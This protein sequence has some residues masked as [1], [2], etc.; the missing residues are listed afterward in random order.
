MQSARILQTL[1]FHVAVH[2]PTLLYLECHVVQIAISS[3]EWFSFPSYHK[4]PLLPNNP[5]KVCEYEIIIVFAFQHIT[6]YHLPRANRN[7]VA[8]HRLLL[9]I[10]LIGIACS[11]L[12]NIRFNA[13]RYIDIVLGTTDTIWDTNMRVMHSLYDTVRDES[14]YDN[15]LSLVD[16]TVLNN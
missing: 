10:I 8:Y 14:G 11:T 6:S 5:E 9:L 12:T 3:K 2:C 1:G 15:S 13:L 4:A 7:L 16:D